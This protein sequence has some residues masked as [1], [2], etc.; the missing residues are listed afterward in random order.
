MSLPALS[1]A[2]HLV[3][4]EAIALIRFPFWWYTKGFRRLLRWV[5]NGLSYRWKSY[6]IGLWARHL[7]T[8]MY[9]EY[10]IWGRVVSF[11]MRVVVVIART[12][13]WVVEALACFILILLW[14]IWPAAAL[15]GFVVALLN[16]G[17]LH[18]V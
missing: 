1:V 18:L 2:S 16:Q 8:P 12:I 7:M 15:I 4:E 14:L 13:A 9:G 6:A 5:G 11:I 10:S 17:L 3:Q